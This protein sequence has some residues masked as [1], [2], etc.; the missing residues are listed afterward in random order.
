MGTQETG[1]IGGAASGAASGFAVGGPWGAVIGG[2]IGG[3]SGFLS[4]GGEDEVRELAEAQAEL[5][6]KTAG[7]NLRRQRMQLG[8][9]TGQMTAQIAASNVQ[10]SG[11]STKYRDVYK[12][13]SIRQM[14]WNMH[15]A[16]L[17]ADAIKKGGSATASAM[18]SAGLGQMVSSVGGAAASGA[19][20][21]YSKAGGYKSPW[22]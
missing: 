11:S 2:V 6:L 8:Q 15:K 13:E 22:A 1:A 9:E 10:F 16:R 21:T 12:S 5:H 7:E 14:S 3:V 20:G 19:F 4:G 18:E 17:E